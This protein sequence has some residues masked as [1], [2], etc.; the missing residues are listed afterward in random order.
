MSGDIQGRGVVK[1]YLL[2]EL[3]DAER[4][5]FEVQMM[6][7][8]E[9]FNEMLLVEEDLVEAYVH[10]TMSR[11]ERQ[12]F[13]L[14]YMSTVEGREQVSF[15]RALGKY[16]KSRAAGHAHSTQSGKVRRPIVSLTGWF[17]QLAGS[18]YLRGAAAALLVLG[19]G[20][21]IWRTLIYESDVSKGLKALAYAYREQR[22]TE[23]RI[24]GF[25]YAPVAST[26]GDEDKSDEAARDLAE[27]ILLD[28]VFQHPSPAAHHALGRLYLAEGRLDDAIK[29]FEESLK[30]DSNNAQLHSDYGAAL[31]GKANAAE[32]ANERGEALFNKSNALEHLT[33][34]R[35]LDGSLLE[36]LFNRALCYESML[37]P[38][39][40]AEDW[41]EYLRRDPNSKWADE[42]RARLRKIEDKDI[43]SSQTE[44]QPYEQFITAYHAKDRKAAWTAFSSGRQRAGNLVVEKLAD[45]C[46][47]RPLNSSSREGSKS[48]SALLYAGELE[49]EMAGDR[50]TLDFARFY[51]RLSPKKQ[52]ALKDARALIRKAQLDIA[53]SDLKSAFGKYENAR[54]AFDGVGDTCEAKTSDYW[55]S[56]CLAEEID[57]LRAPERFRELSEVCE[58]L[59][60]KWLV[61]RASNALAN[62]NLNLNEYSRVIRYSTRSRR[63]A[64]Q[65]QDTYG[66]VLALSNLIQAYSSLGNEE[67]A[68]DSL[69]QLLTLAGGSIEPIQ[70]CLCFARAAWTLYALDLLAAALDYQKAALARAVELDELRMIC[71]SY[72]HLGLIQARLRDFD[73]AFAN[74][75]RAS[76]IA[77]SRSNERP[78]SLMIAYSDLHLASLY[79]QKGD[80]P[81][82]IESYN[83]A[84][85]EY[86]KLDFTPFV[87][88]AHKGLVLSYIASGDDSSA[89]SEL[90]KAIGYYEDHRSKIWD[91]ANRNTFFDR[92]NDIYDI[93]IGFEYSRKNSPQ[94]AFEYSELSRGRTLLDLIKRQGRV[95]DQDP[96][97]EPGLVTS[98]LSLPK[99]QEQMPRPV[100]V[101][102]Y[103]VLEDKLLIWL[104]THSAVQAVEQPITARAL[105]DLVQDYSRLVSTPGSDIDT[106]SRSGRD[107]FKLL[108]GPV[109]PF[110]QRDAHLFIVAD[111]CLNNVPFQSLISSTTGNYLIEDFSV[112]LSPSSSVLIACTEDADRK[113]EISRES[114][115]SVGVTHF[116]QGEYGKLRNLPS[117][118][119]EA[120]GVA[121][122]YPSSIALI[123]EHARK[124]DVLREMENANVIHLASHFI[125][126]DSS[127]FRSSLLL[128]NEP[129]RDPVSGISS[130]VLESSEIFERKLPA[131]KLVVL[132]ACQ[133]G[134]ERYYYRG[135]GAMSL[136]RAF[137]AAGAP[138]VLAS[139]WA[140]DSDSTT[141]LM[142]EFHH[143]RKYEVPSSAE[144]LRR[145]QVKMLKGADSRYKHP[146]Y[147]ASFNLIGGYAKY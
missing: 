15:A 59:D 28:A 12:R 5:R 120:T 92:V 62:H 131:A 138:L 17:S 11:N 80:L 20:L 8:T 25:D 49:F 95:D 29:H 34:A 27:R 137:I 1:Q 76:E 139:L 116:G 87:H 81:A 121:G 85:D 58:K 42:A 91:Q 112:A 33:T 143:N 16:V 127:P 64:E 84:L 10:G 54:L 60:Y 44:A 39:K 14:S 47:A 4:E 130:G 123:R 108:I 75:R 46:L 111:K 50:F 37:L 98:P 3:T 51:A 65:I 115:L 129:G 32:S 118:A 141:A 73:D 38:Q 61:I 140:V 128:W 43:R 134:V 96:E 72:V 100:Q 67:Q 57:P 63:L 147:W 36:A 94:A 48:L 133:T 102:Q 124:K 145:A 89:E 125:S 9:L 7:D 142:T 19:L 109:E 136:A 55:M 117:A 119:N 2:G 24:S 6:S 40:A 68:L 52:M 18:P 107:L 26:R 71:T 86:T 21:G 78:G 30:G 144:A 79:R 126:S 74:I 110:L 77:H 13:E 35:N 56:I 69:Q 66:L 22:P 83:K 99:I 93:A 41:Q 135:E 82:A 114:A 146:Y 122:N 70:S 90:R 101:I 23:T 88:E 105:S 31:I 45:D 104:V 97:A 53:R 106:V 132:S 113:R 103:A